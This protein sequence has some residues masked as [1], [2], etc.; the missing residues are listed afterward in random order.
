MYLLLKNG[1]FFQSVMLLF[2]D[3]FVYDRFCDPHFKYCWFR[4]P[5]PNHLGYIYI[6]YIKPCKNHGINYLSLPPSNW[7][8]MGFLKHINRMGVLNA[9]FFR[10]SAFRSFGVGQSNQPTDGWSS[11]NVNNNFLKVSFIYMSQNVRTFRKA[12]FFLV[13]FWLNKNCTLLS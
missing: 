3:V 9:F 1:G 12:R 13:F 2:S 5:I 7:L 4:N 8:G 11:S 10:L 6:L